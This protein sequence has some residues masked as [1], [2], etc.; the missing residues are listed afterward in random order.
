M[1]CLVA[2]DGSRRLGLLWGPWKPVPLA[3]RGAQQAPR[4]PAA[5]TVP[6]KP[7]L[8]QHPLTFWCSLRRSPIMLELLTML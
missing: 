3:S 4:P 6:G 8:G 1:T 7:L 5:G 2:G